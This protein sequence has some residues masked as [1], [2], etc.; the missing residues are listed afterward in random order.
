MRI[1]PKYWQERQEELR[2]YDFKMGRQLGSLS[3]D[4]QILPMDNIPK[5]EDYP[6]LY[7]R[8]NQ[9]QAELNFTLNKLNEHLDAQRKDRSIRY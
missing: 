4:V 5:S 9:L 8:I 3:P 6:P 2:R 1:N 7:N